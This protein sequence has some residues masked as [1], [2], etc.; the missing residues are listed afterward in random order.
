MLK[1]VNNHLVGGIMLQSLGVLPVMLLIA[2]FALEFL[3]GPNALS[4]LAPWI[5]VFG[6]LGTG[7]L[8]GLLLEYSTSKA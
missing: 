5:A 3:W 2:G 8:L 1:V 4:G 7:G 6:I